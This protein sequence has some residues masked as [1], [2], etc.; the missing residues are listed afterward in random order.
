MNIFALIPNAPSI[1]KWFLLYTFDIFLL[2]RE[3]YCNGGTLLGKELW[4]RK[5]KESFTGKLEKQS[6]ILKK[7]TKI[8]LLK[9]TQGGVKMTHKSFHCGFSSLSKEATLVLTSNIWDTKDKENCEY[10]HLM[11][12]FWPL[13]SPR[14][15][16]PNMAHKVI[17]LSQCSNLPDPI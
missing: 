14:K 4:R 1:F 6:K 12:D 5:D 11:R 9:N 13:H 2:I 8:R 7:H 16:N 17:S 3:F 15:G 10:L